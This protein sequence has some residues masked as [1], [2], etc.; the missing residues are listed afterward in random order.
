MNFVSSVSNMYRDFDV[1][2]QRKL[3]SLYNPEICLDPQN[4]K[5]L[6]SAS[7]RKTLNC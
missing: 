4:P 1:R 5:T 6:N 2:A 3:S 7:I